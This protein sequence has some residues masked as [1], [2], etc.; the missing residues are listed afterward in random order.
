MANSVSQ[1]ISLY[2]KDYHQWLEMTTQ[3]LRER[4]FNTVDIEH[5]I[6]EISAMGRNEKLAIKS[7]LR[8]LIIQ[9]LKWQ[10]Q[11]QNR[12]NEWVEIIS[13]YRHKL[14]DI[15]LESQGLKTFGLSVLQ[16]CY[17]N[18]CQTMSTEDH[19]PVEHFPTELFS[20]ESPF[21]FEQVLDIG[22]FPK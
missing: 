14:N 2:E 16:T 5:L 12:S 17:Q 21:S 9:L 13:E 10:H 1:P 18:A 4:V 7:Y 8:L 11:P 6:D 22:Y 19:L 20:E 15:L 3:L